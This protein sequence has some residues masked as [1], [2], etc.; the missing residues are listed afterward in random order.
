VFAARSCSG[1]KAGTAQRPR[2]DGTGVSEKKQSSTEKQT[3]SDGARMSLLSL[4]QISFPEMDPTTDTKLIFFCQ[5]KANA[6]TF[7]PG[8]LRQPGP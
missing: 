6:A 4:R 3:V 7:P 2:L 5:I 8:F 1:S